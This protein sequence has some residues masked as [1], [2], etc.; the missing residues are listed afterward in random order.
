MY[1]QCECEVHTVKKAKLK[2][3]LHLINTKERFLTASSSVNI[4]KA[5][6][7]QGKGDIALVLR[8]YVHT[9]HPY[10][11]LLHVARPHLCTPEHYFCNRSPL[12]IFKST[13]Q[14]F[15]S[16]LC[17]ANFSHPLS[18]SQILFITL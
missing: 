11:I 15:L 18:P 8:L 6:I 5:I 2:S 13:L 4:H 17:Y 7:H 1:V 14:V 3:W 9:V 10:I 12:P 16:D